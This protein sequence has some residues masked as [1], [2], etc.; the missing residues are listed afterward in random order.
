[1]IVVHSRDQA[2]VGMAH[3]T[4]SPRNQLQFFQTMMGQYWFRKTQPKQALRMT[5]NAF[6]KLQQNFK[7]NY[8]LE[9]STDWV[10]DWLTN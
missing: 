8:L 1:M 9:F 4:N 10:T 3:E 7:K 5:W 2:V 6:K